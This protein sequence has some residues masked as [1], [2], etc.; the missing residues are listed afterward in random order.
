[1]DAIRW[2]EAGLRPGC[3]GQGWIQL[4]DVG[5]V[6]VNLRDMGSMKGWSGVV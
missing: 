1:M 5:Q 2:R 3:A 4:A 6:R